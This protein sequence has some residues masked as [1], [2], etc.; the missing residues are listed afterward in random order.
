MASKIV[1][2]LTPD[3]ALVINANYSPSISDRRR[4][5]DQNR[6]AQRHLAESVL[7]GQQATYFRTNVDIAIGDVICSAALA[8]DEADATVAVRVATKADASALGAANAVLGIAATAAK[9]GSMVRAVTGGLVGKN[10]TGLPVGTAGFVRV[11]S[12]GRPEFISSPTSGDFL[13]GSVDTAGN[14]SVSFSVAS[15]GGG[16]SAPSYVGTSASPLAVS[17]GSKTF[18]TQSGLAYTL[19]SRVRLAST[20]NSAN[21]IEGRVTAYS[22]TSM[23]VFVDVIGGSGTHSD[24][25]LSLAGEPG[26][27][28]G[29]GSGTG[30]AAVYLLANANITLNGLQTI[31][32]VS[33]GNGKRIGVISQSVGSQNGIWISSSSG[34]WS[35]AS[36]WTVGSTVLNGEQFT[37]TDGTQYTGALVQVATGDPIVVGT[38]A[39]SFR[40]IPFFNTAPHDGKLVAI[41]SGI[42]NATKLTNT[43]VDDNT[44][45]PAKIAGGGTPKRVA[46]TTAGGAITMAQL[47]NDHVATNADIAV[48]KIAVLADTFSGAALPKQRF[49]GSAAIDVEDL[50]GRNVLRRT[51]IVHLSDHVPKTGWKTGRVAMTSGSTAATVGGGYTGFADG[52][53]V[54]ICNVGAANTLTTPPT[55]T[56]TVI[57]QD[58]VVA[59]TVYEYGFVYWNVN[60]GRSVC[61]TTASI[62]GPDVLDA[63]NYIRVS[64]GTAASIP[65]DVYIIQV[66]RRTVTVNGV[67][68]SDRGWKNLGGIV[69]HYSSGP[70]N[71][72]L[73][74]QGTE[75]SH[76]GFTYV[77]TV[78][79]PAIPTSVGRD[80][81]HTTIVSGGGTTSL[82][83]AHAAQASVGGSDIRTDIGPELQALIDANPTKAVFIEDGDWPIG[84]NIVFSG[85]RILR[86]H[87]RENTI[88]LFAPGFN[89]TI[90]YAA[91]FSHVSDLTW[92]AQQKQLPNGAVVAPRRND[93]AETEVGGTVEGDTD[94]RYPGCGIY[95]NT[96]CHLDNVKVQD[97]FGTGIGI[98]GSSTE[99]TNANRTKV[100][101]CEVHS[102]VYHGVFV[103]GGDSNVCKLLGISVVNCCDESGGAI[104]DGEISPDVIDGLGTN[105]NRGNADGILDSSFL[106]IDVDTYHFSGIARPINQWQDTAASTY[107]QVYIESGSASSFI[108]SANV[109]SGANGGGYDVNTG[110][111]TIIN[112]NVFIRPVNFIVA[113]GA[114]RVWEP[115]KPQRVGW[116][117]RPTKNN[118]FRYRV[119][120]VGTTSALKD[121]YTGATE[122]TWPTGFGATVTNGSGATQLTLENAGPAEV[123]RQQDPVGHANTG[124]GAVIDF[125]YQGED[126][127]RFFAEQAAVLKFS[128]GGATAGWYR[129]VRAFEGAVLGDASWCNQYTAGAA[130]RITGLDHFKNG[131]VVGVDE[132]TSRIVGFVPGAP[133]SLGNWGSFPFEVG[134][135]FHDT[136]NPGRR[137]TPAARCANTTVW[138]ANTGYKLGQCVR[139]TGGA[140]A[141]SAYVVVAINAASTTNVGLSH[142][143]TEPTWTSTPAATF[144]DNGV[145]W[146]YW[147]VHTG[148]W[149]TLGSAGTP[150]HSAARTTALA[151][152]DLL[153]TGH[154]PG[155]YRVRVNGAVTTNDGAAGTLAGTI[156][157]TGFAG[158]KTVTAFAALNLATA[159][160]EARFSTDIYS[161]GAAAI[162]FTT[163]IT[164][165][166]GTSQHRL[167]VELIRD[168]AQ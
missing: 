165:S 62:T 21:Y 76:P 49:R 67:A 122:P 134:D 90:P 42:T 88:L 29:S 107:N 72:Q 102:A 2:D 13:L 57:N 119:K 55:P 132:A 63:K 59:T 43:H 8:A 36:D 5:D 69:P 125:I 44:I 39:L 85:R 147:G 123:W 22:G 89:L 154:A 7:R 84:C 135:L 6:G 138:A 155:W 56:L 161:T 20:A 81:L 32:S 156:G 80:R 93:V 95:L 61:S 12:V 116:Y 148:V 149:I 28:G 75:F 111:G 46:Q 109:R 168:S 51:D 79:Y 97:C 87:S 37:V 113:G 145:T 103:S 98:R 10:T 19:A 53:I 153:A 25:A 23:T 1:T 18:L 128:S 99:D 110:G 11:S 77:L 17:A 118:G 83:L 129:I 166:F 58:S 60:W 120:R 150:I 33:S 157:F 31:D 152:T 133:P 124:N 48:S 68:A 143:T 41:A 70:V 146:M 162:T 104:A 127:P 137:Y 30:R 131:Y 86:G 101:D 160:D 52:D 108:R 114:S 139:P 54:S 27:G 82:V 74:D 126:G 144:T 141:A 16:G 136:S 142:A 40:V 115:N 9:A 164:G 35:R 92:H 100:Y 73:C 3:D 112:G 34:A 121:G 38:T 66:I 151:S 163:A 106:G 94:T 159:N 130:S 64:A 47:D 158:A 45:S 105:R 26:S 15:V 14:L 78:A 65:N 71:A 117:L 140:H 91:Q 96:E 24:W 167:D 4:I 50:S